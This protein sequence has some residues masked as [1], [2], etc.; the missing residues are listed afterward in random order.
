M[1][2][3]P[4]RQRCEGAASLLGRLARVAVVAIIFMLPCVVVAQPA[5]Q[6]Q[7]DGAVKEKRQGVPVKD[8]EDNVFKRMA[9]AERHVRERKYD[10]ATKDYVW[11]WNESLKVAP[12]FVGVRGSFLA[13]DMKE[14]A[15][16]DEGAR[17]VF[18]SLREVCQRRL[19]EHG[20]SRND[21]DDWLVLNRVVSQEHLSLAWF[22]QV[23][24]N[25]EFAPI[26]RRVLF[27]L[28]DLLIKNKQFADYGRFIESP[29]QEVRN[30]HE[31]V[32]KH[33]QDMKP[34]KDGKLPEVD[35][36]ML[37]ISLKHFREHSTNVYRCLLAVGREEEAA[38]VASEAA[39]LDN[40]A[41]TRIQLVE[42]A[43]EADQARKEQLEIL[44][45]AQKAGE[46]SKEAGFDKSVVE[47]L[48]GQVR[49]GIHL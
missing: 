2:A 47:D 31:M 45:A 36:I 15:D 10:N 39:R 33:K 13:G 29:I 4:R 25:P 14:L 6:G 12:A 11:L 37:D 18:I 5:N 34:D 20:E 17:D 21:R 9:R 40:T 3:Y 26:L 49:A 41:K 43:L 1:N 22:D 23:K 16:L 30:A 8:D 24:D 38:K 35:T 48:K 46:E 32:A 27:R 19:D 44:D 28:Y 7:P 42:G